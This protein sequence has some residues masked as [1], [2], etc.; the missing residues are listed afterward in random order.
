MLR[1]GGGRLGRG[2]LLPFLFGLLVVVLYYFLFCRIWRV[3][4][5]KAIKMDQFTSDNGLFLWLG[6][7]PVGSVSSTS[8]CQVAARM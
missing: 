4:V 7:R 5:G 6:V 1:S 2:L 3:E 8:R